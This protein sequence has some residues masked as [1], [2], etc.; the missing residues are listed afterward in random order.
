MKAIIYSIYFKQI[1]IPKANSI[2][3]LPNNYKI[4][5]I[6]NK[7]IQN[8]TINNWC[9]DGKHFR[10]SYLQKILSKQ[11]RVLFTSNWITH[12]FEHHLL[13]MVYV[14]CLSH[15]TRMAFRNAL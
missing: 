12:D 6:A 9:H 10:V 4:V 11:F 15:S 2:F 8:G 5:N 3:R 14:S 1:I 7:Q 13:W